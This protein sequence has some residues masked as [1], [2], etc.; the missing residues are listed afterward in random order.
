VRLF[1]WEGR[2]GR[3]RAL[4]LLT[5]LIANC[6]R[7]VLPRSPLAPVAMSRILPQAAALPHATPPLSPCFATPSYLVQAA[8]PSPTPTLASRS[9]FA[10]ASSDGVQ[11]VH[12]VGGR[13]GRAGRVLGLA[14]VNML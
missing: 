6:G 13:R 4:A 1:V 10:R 14:V 2:G 8:T 12:V 5:I 9:P 11:A 3:R 7:L